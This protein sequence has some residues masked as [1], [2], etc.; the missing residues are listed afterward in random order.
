MTHWGGQ[1]IQ[2]HLVDKL[3]EVVNASH[4]ASGACYADC[5]CHS[6][7]HQPTEPFAESALGMLLSQLCQ[8][9][10]VRGQEKDGVRERYRP[11]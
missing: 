2:P 9:L 5:P 3:R 4:T 10:L 1:S 7:N 11:Q 6:M 8:Q